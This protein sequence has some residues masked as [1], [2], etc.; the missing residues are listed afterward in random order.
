VCH[1]TRSGG[2]ARARAG[3]VIKGIT[4]VEEVVANELEGRAM[5]LVG[6]GFRDDVDNSLDDAASPGLVVRLNLKL[7]DG[8]DHGQRAVDGF[9]RVGI[10]DAV[11]VVQSGAV[12]LALQ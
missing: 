7:L 1:Q 4:C 6:A 11:H 2:R 9:P 5:H 10:G 3:D 8:V 12:L